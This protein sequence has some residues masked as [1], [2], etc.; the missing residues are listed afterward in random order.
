MNFF[1]TRVSRQKRNGLPACHQD[2]PEGSFRGHPFKL[3][4][5]CT[6]G[7]LP[8]CVRPGER[9]QAALTFFIIVIRPL[10][11][12]Q[13]ERAIGSGIHVDIDR[14]IRLLPGIFNFRPHGKDGAGPDKYGHTGIGCLGCK[15]LPC[16]VEFSGVEIVPALT[17]RQINS[18]LPLLVLSHR[19]NQQ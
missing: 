15:R 5:S 1:I 18:T 16:G 7:Q 10:V 9:D 17:A 4:L 12:I 6:D 13:A 2:D 19:A 3:P 11:F 14:R 8:G